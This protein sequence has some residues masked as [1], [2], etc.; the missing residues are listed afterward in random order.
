LSIT[1]SRKISSFEEYWLASK[2]RRRRGLTLRAPRPLVNSGYLA[3]DD[4]HK[5]DLELTTIP[6]V[7]CKSLA[8]LDGVTGREQS[9]IG[10]VPNNRKPGWISIEQPTRAA[11]PRPTEHAMIEA[12]IQ[13][14]LITTEQAEAVRLFL[15]RAVEAGVVSAG[16]P[17]A[18]S[19]PHGSERI[20]L[21]EDNEQVRAVAVEQ[22]TSLG[23]CV[24][25]T[26]NGDTA[27]AL[28]EKKSGE[29]DLVFSDMTMPGLVD[30]FELA[31]LVLER[32]PSKKV[33]LT[34][35]FSG[36]VGDKLEE[37]AMGVTVIRKPYR[38]ADLARAV[39]ATLAA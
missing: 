7:G 5:H 38:K 24:V 4:L 10:T 17:K 11:P 14:D 1:I 19:L 26:E 23:Y 2:A 3:L 15:P 20:L 29:F 32:W 12:A 31:Q 8:L 13:L 33:L 22:L 21:V 35:G 30:G 34:S 18:G 27:L 39:R 37:Q 6:T 16:R 25:E 36:G 9:A 28:L